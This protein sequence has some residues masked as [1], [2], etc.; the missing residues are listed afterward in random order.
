MAAKRDW[1]AGAI[2]KPGSLRATA[3]RDGM[4]KGKQKLSQADIDK[5][6]HSKSATTRRRAELAHT[7]LGFH[8]K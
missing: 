7:L 5:L 1:I 3:K 8:K 2:K 4:V 6:E